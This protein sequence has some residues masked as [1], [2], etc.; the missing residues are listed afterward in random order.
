MGPNLSYWLKKKKILWN[1]KISKKILKIKVNKKQTKNKDI[2]YS[3]IGK[4]TDKIYRK[5]KYKYWDK[6]VDFIR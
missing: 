2:R 6:I 4:T 3:K 1:F 5:H